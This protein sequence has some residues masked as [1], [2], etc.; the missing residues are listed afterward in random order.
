MNQLG[1]YDTIIV[2]V[3]FPNMLPL[4]DQTFNYAIIL[5]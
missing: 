1:F 2:I 3:V 4:V 5:V